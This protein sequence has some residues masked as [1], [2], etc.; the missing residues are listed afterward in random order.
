MVGL[1]ATVMV[2]THGTLTGKEP[3]AKARTH[4]HSMAVV[5]VMPTLKV[6]LQ[7][8]V[9]EGDLLPPELVDYKMYLVPGCKIS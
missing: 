1:K 7:P 3:A 6:H 9:V 5:E 8:P 4:T 2:V